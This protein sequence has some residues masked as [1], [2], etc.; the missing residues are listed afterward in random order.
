V[1]QYIVS[2]KVMAVGKTRRSN[3][4]AA[5]KMCLGRRRGREGGREGGRSGWVGGRGSIQAVR[6]SRVF[7][8][9]RRILEGRKRERRKV[10]RGRE[11]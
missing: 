3:V 10:D 11:G 2:M 4:R 8:A 5:M 9:E 1:N 7:E 6:L